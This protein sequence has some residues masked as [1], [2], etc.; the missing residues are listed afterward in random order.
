MRFLFEPSSQEV[1]TK[2][3]KNQKKL[4]YDV[5]RGILKNGYEEKIKEKE[6]EYFCRST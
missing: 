4:K 3:L 1:A 5:N 2:K 6:K